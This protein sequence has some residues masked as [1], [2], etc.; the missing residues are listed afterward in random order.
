[1]SEYSPE[2]DT[3]DNV[4]E[5][6]PEGQVISMTQAELSQA[7]EDF[8]MDFRYLESILIQARKAK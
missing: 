2:F 4:I 3:I 7:L 5:L 6:Y 8:E 1:M